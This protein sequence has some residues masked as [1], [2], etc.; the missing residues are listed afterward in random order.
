MNVTAS[1]YGNSVSYTPEDQA[2]SA[3][4]DNF[5]TAWITGTFVPD[6]AGQWWQAQLR[7]SRHRPTTSRWSS[8]SGAT[9][10]AGCRP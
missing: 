4:D 5:D 2:Y 7:R 1:S 8:P 10:R 6:P 3:I 9:A